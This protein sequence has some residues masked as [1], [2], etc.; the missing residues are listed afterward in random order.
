MSVSDEELMAYVDGEL[1][2]GRRV[3]VEREIAANSGLAVRVAAQQALRERL[4][5]ALD[6]TLNEPVPKRLSEAVRG[7]SVVDFRGASSRKRQRQLVMTY[8]LAAAASLVLGVLIGPW[9]PRLSGEQ[10]DIVTRGSSLVAD[11]TLAE[12]LSQ[13]LASEQSPSERVRLVMSFVSDSGEYCRTFVANRQED[14]TTGI[15]CLKSDAWRIRALDTAAAA[16]GEHGIYRQAATPLSPLILQAI[17]SSMVGQPLDA[18][19][20]AAAR[21]KGWRRPAMAQTD[22]PKR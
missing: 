4:H 22:Q 7:S 2:A 17:E 6:S 1:D 13:R 8:W 11:G 9:I 16:A 21:N 14:S 10:P 5:R 12:A 18:D 15:A 3:A 20:E 19:G